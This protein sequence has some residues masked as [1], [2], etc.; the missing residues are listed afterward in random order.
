MCSYLPDVDHELVFKEKERSR[1]QWLP[2]GTMTTKFFSSRSKSPIT[3]SLDSPKTRMV[4]SF[5]HWLP[6]DTFVFFPSSHPYSLSSG[7]SQNAD[8][9]RIPGL[10]VEKMEKTTR[11]LCWRWRAW[12]WDIYSKDLL[13][14]H[15]KEKLSLECVLW[16]WL[17][18][19][20]NRSRKEYDPRELSTGT[21]DRKEE[22]C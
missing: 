5:P 1:V 15:V 17:L 19:C 16:K 21:Q 6:A 14:K 7:Y 22:D 9:S 10:G 8:V 3:V 18:G 13:P 11:C 4:K 20:Y 12:P 2:V